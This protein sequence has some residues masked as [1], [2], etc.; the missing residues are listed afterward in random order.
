MRIEP[1]GMPQAQA[2]TQP[3]T[4]A[5]EARQRAIATLTAPSS[6]QPQQPVV[7]NQSAI[8]PEEMTAIAPKSQPAL[9]EPESGQLDSSVETPPPV[10][11]K[12]PEQDPAL[13]RQFAKLAQQEKAMRARAQAAE[14][15][16]KAREA[17]LTAREAEL[18]AKDGVYQKDYIQRD[19][20]KQDP[21]SI[22]A[23][24]GVSYEELTQQ[25]L[26]Q[27]PQD[28]RTQATISR[29]EAKIRELEAK[30]EQATKSSTEQQQQAYQAA[31]K[32]IE[33]DAKKL[34]FTDPS[35]ETIKATNSTKDVVELI[36]RTYNEDGVLLSVE[37]AAQQVEDYLVEEAMKITQIDK[38]KKR[39]A[40][41]AQ[42]KPNAEQKTP[43]QTQQQPKAMNTLTNA[44]TSQRKL[45]GRERAMLAFKGELK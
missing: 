12:K 3:S 6:P 33:A 44:T 21:L 18:A 30:A 43:D 8:T 31:V 1:V 22:L 19:Q 26:N 39:M 5:Q 32:Q 28:P 36:T 23:E 42:P 20:L 24:A 35:Y 9:S 38:I 34:V 2:N 16:V 14:Q 45:S 25:I 41:A 17:A 29:M 7:Q 37:E 15:A 4:S 10:E 40:M 27:Q 13:S 11:A